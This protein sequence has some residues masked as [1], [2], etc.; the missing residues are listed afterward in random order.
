MEGSVTPHVRNLQFVG[1]GKT[2]LKGS[3]NRYVIPTGKSMRER[4]VDS[5]G[6][7]K[8][9]PEPRRRMDSDVLA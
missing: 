9:E 8:G 4:S 5:A 6:G 3:L 7:L 2:A 1:D